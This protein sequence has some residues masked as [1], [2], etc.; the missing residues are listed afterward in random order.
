MSGEAPGGGRV[1]D[2]EADPAESFLDGVRDAHRRPDAGGR[3]G[4]DRSPPGEPQ[5]GPYE[6]GETVRAPAH[7][8]TR[9]DGVDTLAGHLRL[10]ESCPVTTAIRESGVLG[11]I[12][13]V[14]KATDAR[15]GTARRVRVTA[16]DVTRRV[17]VRI[18]RVPNGD[19]DGF[20]EDLAAQ[21]RRWVVVSD[22]DG[23]VPILDRGGQAQPWVVTANTGQTLSGRDTP[24]VT[25]ALDQATTLSAALAD[26]HE[27]GVIHAGIDPG[28]V[29]VTDEDGGSPEPRLTNPGLVDVYRRYEDPAAVLDPRYAPPEF[30]ESA[31]SLVDRATDVYGLGVVC[32]RLFTGV[33]P[34]A[35]SAETIANRVTADEPLPRPSLVDPRL[36]EA[37]D[38]VILRA[39]ATNRYERFETAG[40]FHDALVAVAS[41]Y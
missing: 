37:L 24:S 29:V 28:N 19:R 1:P 39:T 7:A 27:R 36:P 41:E 33:A 10:D 2:E 16:D 25:H 13:A 21:L 12:T 22:V 14:S 20:G 6:D 30:F 38:D 17:T 31:S 18:C 26:L 4:T 34:I 3:V 35:G 32:F 8:S 9:S 23:V 40:E 5:G 15:Y 11:G